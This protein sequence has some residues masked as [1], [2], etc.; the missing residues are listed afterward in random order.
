MIF[1][2]F[3][4]QLTNVLSIQVFWLPFCP[5]PTSKSQV[6]ND[7][8]SMTRLPNPSIPEHH[9]SQ[10]ATSVGWP[11]EPA[12]EVSKG[13]HASQQDRR[14]SA[15]LTT[16]PSAARAKAAWAPGSLWLS[17]SHENSSAASHSCFLAGS[18]AKIKSSGMLH[19]VVG[20]KYISMLST[21]YT[22]ASLW[23]F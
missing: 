7:A 19:M 15:S 8:A 22:T 17:A 6:M 16:S 11:P 2:Y 13:S 3:D 4:S 12:E 20:S 23:P 9:S 1:E 10:F 5:H 21:R 18:G 14:S